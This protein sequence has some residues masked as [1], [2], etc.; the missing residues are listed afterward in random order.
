MA[1]LRFAALDEVLKRKPR[2]FDNPYK[3]TSEFFGMNVFDDSKMQKYLSK[4]AYDSIKESV[5]SGSRIDYKIAD[6]IATGMKAWAMEMGATHYTHWFHP[7]TDETAEKHDA[8]IDWG[9]NGTII[10]SFSGKKLV[11]QEPDA[12]GFPSGGLRN[13]FEARGYTAWDP[14]SPAFI[15]GKTL[16][17]PTIFVSYTGEALDQKTPL[18]KSLIAIDKAAVDVCEYFDKNVTKVFSNLGWEQ[19]FYLIDE[20]LYNA[21]LD[22]S[23]TDR[24]LM[25]CSSAKNQQLDDHYF[26]SIPERAAAFMHELEF[27]AYKLGIPVK[28]R[29]NEVAPN[30][31]EVA[32]L[33]EETNLAVDH[34]LLMMDIMRRIARHHHFRIIFHEKPF[35][36]LN[37]SGKHSNWSLSTDTG[38]I[39]H[40][41]GKN[42]KSNLQ[43]LTVGAR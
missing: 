38:V 32:P 2:F 23:L 12:S 27:E 6:Q 13:T 26:G 40:A 31:F 21:R 41:P 37:G 30:Q 36:S 18:L 16:S 28:T 10:E 34:N 25:G 19:E 39:L 15:V 1:I 33:F 11:Q 43:F 35:K 7:L 22:L 4:E 14:S 5:W 24:T 8:F 9:E 3:K 29:H 20:A 17:I 42:P